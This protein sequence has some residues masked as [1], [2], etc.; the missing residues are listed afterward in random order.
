[1]FA[2]EM[3]E[4]AANKRVGVWVSWCYL[5]EPSGSGFGSVF[6][7]RDHSDPAACAKH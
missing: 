6:R 1:M 2:V 3:T 4:I 7:W 5:P